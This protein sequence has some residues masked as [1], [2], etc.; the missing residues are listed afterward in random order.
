MNHYIIKDMCYGGWFGVLLF[1]LMIAVW[2][3][4]I[5][6]LCRRNNQT[7]VG[8]VEIILLIA[9]WRICLSIIMGFAYIG[10]L[11]MTPYFLYPVHWG[12]S[13]ATPLMDATALSL[14]ILL[15]LTLRK[16]PQPLKCYLLPGVLAGIGSVMVVYYTVLQGFAC[17]VK[18]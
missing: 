7:A 15:P 1:G 16:R 2:L 11:D 3:A 5:V 14:A 4:G 17:H 10:S 8:M 9:V 13:I 6:C 12:N 18:L